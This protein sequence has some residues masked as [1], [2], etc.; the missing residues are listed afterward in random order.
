[1]ASPTHSGSTT[2]TRT[3]I[4]S[5]QDPHGSVYEVWANLADCQMLTDTARLQF[6]SKWTRSRDP[7]SFHNI[8]EIYLDATGIDNLRRL[9]GAK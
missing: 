4:S 3:L 2:S 8:A 5:N 1:M 9:L 7:D 6:Q